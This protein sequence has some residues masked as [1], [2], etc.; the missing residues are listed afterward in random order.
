MSRREELQGHIEAL[1]EELR[2]LPRHQFNTQKIADRERALAG[3]RE[4]LANLD[5]IHERFLARQ[6]EL[7]ARCDRFP[8]LRRD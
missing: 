4:H 7:I 5:R 8:V 1:E 6:A 2:R 3:Y